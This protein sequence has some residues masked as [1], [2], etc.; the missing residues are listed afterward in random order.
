[1]RIATDAALIER[2]GVR[3]ET[4]FGIQFNAKMARI[5]SKQIYSNV[6]QAPIREIICNAWDSQRAAG[7]L[8]VPIRVHLPNQWEPWFEVQDEG[9]GLDHDT[10]LRVYTQYGASTKALNNDD[11]G[12]LGLGCKAPFAYA[13]AFSV[14]SVYGGMSR[15]YSL[16]KNERGIPALALL[17]EQPSNS[18]QGVTVRVPVKS[19]DFGRFLQ[20]TQKV[21]RWFDT[22]FEVSGNTHYQKLSPKMDPTFRSSDWYYQECDYYS[23]ESALVIMGNVAYPIQVDQVNPRYRDM[24]QSYSYSLIMHFA[25]GELDVSPTREDLSYDPVTVAMIERKLDLILSECKQIME[26]QLSSCTSLWQARCVVTS[27]GS[28]D[29]ARTLYKVLQS[30]GLSCV[31]QGEQI[32]SQSIY[33]NNVPGITKEEPGAHVMKVTSAHRCESVSYVEPR[34]NVM[35]IL[36]DC[37]DASARARKAYADRNSHVYVIQGDAPAQA[38]MVQYLGAP[39]LI[40]ASSLPKA[41]RKRMPF[42]GHVYKPRDGWGRQYKSHNWGDETALT[43]DQS[44]YYVTQIHW[45]AVNDKDEPIKLDAMITLARELGWITRTD[46][47]WGINKTNSKLLTGSQTWIRFDTWFLEQVKA[48]LQDASLL[49]GMSVQQ[50]VQEMANRLLLQNDGTG[51]RLMMNHWGHMQNTLGELARSYV[52]AQNTQMDI[53][54]INFMRK[55]VIMCKLQDAIPRGVDLVHAWNQVICTY[56]LLE[57]IQGRTDAASWGHMT[58]YVQL[59]DADLAAR[60]REAA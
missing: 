9:V 24:L 21:L 55:A 22:P 46:K 11:I 27:W 29:I 19:Q 16:F 23:R 51:A 41:D 49:M 56:P 2:A 50:T 48:Q 3:D 13:D 10:M 31:W 36:G 53:K 40:L 30:Q 45:D 28:R 25:I 60:E 58:T 57:F 14:V 7:K 47:V 44:G 52:K 26:A 59:M 35:F 34:S 6:I 4:E 8:D 37:A 32:E 38:R 42:K 20:E 1:M 5:L 33:V 17:G 12:G 39:D 54:K 18:P 43:T 15:S